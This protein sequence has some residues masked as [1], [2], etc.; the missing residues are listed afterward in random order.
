MRSDHTA[1]ELTQAQA[2]P[3]MPLDNARESVSK[4]QV[5]ALAR[6]TF[7]FA[8]LFG[9]EP[10]LTGPPDDESRLQQ[11]HTSFALPGTRETPWKKEDGSAVQ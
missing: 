11:P 8:W 2:P 5:R 7:C 6:V 4:R 3:A 9:L 10:F 1:A